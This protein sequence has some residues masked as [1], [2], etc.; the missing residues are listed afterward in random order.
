MILS[1]GEILVD[2]IQTGAT[3]VSHIGGAPFN[4][5]VNAYRRGAEVKFYGAVG[6]DADGLFIKDEAEKY[7]PERSILKVIPERKTTVAMVTLDDGERNFRFLR[8]CAAD[9]ALS[10]DL[11]FSDFSGL[12]ILHLGTLML[13]KESG[14][15]FARFIVDK[16]KEEKVVLSV[17]ANFR[18]DL[19]KNKEE[20]NAVMLPIL[21][22]ADIVKFSDDEILD[23]TGKEGVEEAIL[24]FAPKDYIFVTCGKHGSIAWQ[25]ELGFVYC[26]STPAETV[27]DTTGAGDAYFGTVLALLDG[28]ITAGNEIDKDTLRQVMAEGNEAGKLATQRVGAV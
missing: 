4:V 22:S 20:R 15:Q 16:C 9:Y 18:D 5:A 11:N 21:K 27:V 24:A 17:D 23:I 2:R 10:P 14:R 7:L 3:I 13:N 19:F 6:Q 1:V 12:K 8:E 26:Q 28:F 25:R